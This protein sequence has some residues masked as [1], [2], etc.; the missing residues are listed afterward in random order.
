MPCCAGTIRGDYAVEVGRNIIHGSD[1]VA[2]ATHEIGLW[3]PEGI[4]DWT[5]ALKSWIYE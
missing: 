3:F 1:S 5:P 2:S 4:A